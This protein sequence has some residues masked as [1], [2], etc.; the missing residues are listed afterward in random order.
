MKH[1]RP[2]KIFES[3]KDD[4]DAI[5]EICY[6]I[7]DDGYFDIEITETYGGTE[8]S[9]NKFGIK[10]DAGFVL[11]K[12]TDGTYGSRIA[13]NYKD[14]KS[15]TNMIKNYLEDRY[16]KTIVMLSGEMNWFDLDD[17]KEPYWR[18]SDPH[19]SSGELISHTNHDRI[20]NN[21]NEN[22]I[23]YFVIWFKNT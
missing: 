10:E 12:R 6:D 21:I 16:I 11:I 1:I 3:T 22:G 7:T 15:T 9:K 20:D 2:Y 17:R 8:E 18:L 23:K 4:V 19:R 13:F 5:R 14:I